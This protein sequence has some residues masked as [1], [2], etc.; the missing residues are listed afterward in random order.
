MSEALLG[1][2][3]SALFECERYDEIHASKLELKH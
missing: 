3:R 1:D 2:A